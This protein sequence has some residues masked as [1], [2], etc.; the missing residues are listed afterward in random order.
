VLA[1]WCNRQG[2]RSVVVVSTVGH[3]RRLRRVLHRSL[4]GQTRVMVHTVSALPGFQS[5]PMV[6]KPGVE[7]ALKSRN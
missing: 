6:G 3:S 7:F 1:D 4:R 2:F 5:R